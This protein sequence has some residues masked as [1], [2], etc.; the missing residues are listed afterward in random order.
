MLR[1]QKV[2]AV[3]LSFLLVLT[4]FPVG[5][6]A[7]NASPSGT[8]NTSSSS[9]SGEYQP[10]TGEEL[11]AIVAP[12]ALYPDALV[13]QILGAA[14]F[15]YE[16][17]DAAF[18]IKDNSQLKGEALA[19]A[20]DQQSWDPAVKAL[21]Q[22]PSVLD[23]LA[24]NLAWTSALGEASATQQSDV[25]AA[26]QRMRAKAQAAGNLK[27]SP[28]IKVIQE[29]PQT[30]VIQP[31]NPQVVYVPV[32]NPA[33]IY[34]VPYV[35][36][37]YVYVAPPPST[38]V[39]AFGVGIAVG[40]MVYGGCC[41]W[42]WSYWG[43][44]W[45]GNTIIYNRNIYV[46]NSYWRGGYYG[47]GYRPGY[48]A[49]RPGYPGYGRP[50]GYRPPATTLPSPGN[51]P[52]NR[53]PATTLPSP[54]NRPGNRPPAT[55]LPAGPEYRPNA[56]SGGSRPGVGMPSTLPANGGN[57]R[58]QSPGSRPSTDEARGYHRPQTG[59]GQGTRPNAFSGNVGGRAQSARGSQSM[60]ARS[61]KGGR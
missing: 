29:T 27:S 2:V 22:F 36:P 35:Y 45:R 15:P 4:T 21:T 37:G 18:W 56:P 57:R 55:T 28:E 39:I 11:D 19:K 40:A 61:G 6:N 34:G 16:I 8:Q 24:K 41:G 47:G 54:G 23:N 42:G 53:P 43:T 33:L 38:A 10:L 14:T 32:Y 17:V 44:N 60:S 13:A 7:Q 26:V 49:Y 25:M 3:L 30:I 50:P 59:A 52:G 51:R 12:I 9:P 5:A 58:N 48:P 46:G 1:V 31:A 20:V